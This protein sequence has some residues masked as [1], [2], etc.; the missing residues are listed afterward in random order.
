MEGHSFDPIARFPK[1][2]Q[3]LGTMPDTFKID[4]RGDVVPLNLMVPRRIPAGLR[5]KA[6][7]EIDSMLEK[8]VIEPVE[9]ATEWCSG[10]TIVPK[11]NGGIRMCVDLSELN[12]GVRREAYPLPRVT[13]LLGTLSK[14]IVFF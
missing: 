14:G 2:F 3:G 7:L 11:S 10:L 1:L 8:G 6:K 13:E 4:L 9:D 12:K 5:D